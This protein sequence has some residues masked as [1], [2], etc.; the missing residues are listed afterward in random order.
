MAQNA[1][2][3]EPRRGTSGERLPALA[4]HTGFGPVALPAVAAAAVYAA[5]PLQPRKPTT[6]EIPALLRQLG[7]FD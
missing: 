6:Q 5:R 7:I 4:G 2:T 3:I 1:N